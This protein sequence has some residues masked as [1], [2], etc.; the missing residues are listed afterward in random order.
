M[1]SSVKKEFNKLCSPAKF[2]LV[3][4]A[5]SLLIYIMA[6]MNHVDKMHTVNGL[7][8]Q[9]LTMVIWTL[10]LNWVCSLKYGNKIAWFLVFLPMILVFIM[11]FFMIYLVSE[12]KITSEELKKFVE[13]TK[14]NE[15]KKGFCGSCS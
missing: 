7:A 10:V 15:N 12:K 13:L 5:V 11:I 8:I 14:K 2:Y 4:S 1:S 3:I 6:M 9:T